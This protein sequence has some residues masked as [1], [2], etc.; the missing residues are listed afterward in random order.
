MSGKQN[1]NEN[2]PN[3]S[4]SIYMAHFKRRVTAVPNSK[5]HTKFDLT[6][7][8]QRFG[9]NH[10]T[11]A[12]LNSILKLVVVDTTAAPALFILSDNRILAS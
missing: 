6:A 8:V 7:P 10:R 9:F 4:R 5:S 11:T 2:Q 1:F 3:T 12:V